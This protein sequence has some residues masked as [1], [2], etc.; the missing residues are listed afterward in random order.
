MLFVACQFGCSFKIQ[1][2]EQFNLQFR[3]ICIETDFAHYS[4]A[5]TLVLQRQHATLSE[6][7]RYKGN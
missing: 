6:V 3:G 7:S 5:N 2:R 4:I 1:P